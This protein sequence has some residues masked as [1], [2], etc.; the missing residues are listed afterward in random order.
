MA[1]KRQHIILNQQLCHK[2]KTC[3]SSN[4]S[5]WGILMSGSVFSEIISA[6]N[7]G[8]FTTMIM[9]YFLKF[10]PRLIAYDPARL[11]FPAEIRWV[12]HDSDALYVLSTRFQKFFR[13]TVS[14][15]EIN[16]RIVRIPLGSR[17]SHG[18]GN[19]IYFKK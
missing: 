1:K 19:N 14:P 11:Q 18:F 15:T 17:L 3:F 10:F 12:E 5:S 13:R 6:K 16:L 9:H 7:V 2:S 4:A 8:L